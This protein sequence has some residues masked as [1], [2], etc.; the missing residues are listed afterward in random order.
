[1]T[2]EK[3]R[4]LRKLAATGRVTA[5]INDSRSSRQH[6][7]DTIREVELETVALQMGSHAYERVD[8]KTQFTTLGSN[9]PCNKAS[10][11]DRAIQREE[12]FCSNVCLL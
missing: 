4:K 7:N 12:R 10:H 9:H 3:F 1:M 2:H 6:T 8:D 5:L 11:S